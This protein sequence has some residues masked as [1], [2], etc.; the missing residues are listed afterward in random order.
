MA[1]PH[2]ACVTNL[3]GVFDVLQ[4]F[5]ALQAGLRLGP[6]ASDEGVVGNR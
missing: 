3:E 4:T 1:V 6:G 5:L 2:L